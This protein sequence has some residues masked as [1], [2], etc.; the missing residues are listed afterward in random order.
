MG[1][2]VTNGWFIKR[3]LQ[4]EGQTLARSSEAADIRQGTAQSHDP[5]RKGTVK[6]T[7]VLTMRMSPFPFAKQLSRFPVNVD[8]VWPRCNTTK[9]P[10][11]KLYPPTRR[12]GGFSVQNTQTGHTSEKVSS[13]EVVSHREAA[14]HEGGYSFQNVIG[15]EC[16][17]ACSQ[18]FCEDQSSRQ[19]MST[20]RGA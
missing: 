13:G 9:L 19:N 5:L 10:T 18:R 15:L 12:Q 7:H 1:H 3:W 8:R 14:G 4:D 17:F 20:E 11:G 2:S 16:K 6:K